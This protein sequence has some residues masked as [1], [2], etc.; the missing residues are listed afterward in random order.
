MK[1]IL[2]VSK[3]KS[4]GSATG[5]TSHNY[6]L[7]EV[8]NADPDR[9]HLNQEY[10]NRGEKNI[11]ELATDRIEQAGIKTV[12]KDAVRGM[13][14]LITASP[15]AFP[16]DESGVIKGDY[17]NSTW[18][19]DNLK[20]LSQ[21][22][23]A[24]LVAFTLHQD[25]KTPHI[26]AIVVPITA[27]N[28]LSAKDL[29]NPKTLK[30]LQTDYAQAMQSH[31]LERGVEGSRARHV[32]MQKVY[33]L[34]QQTRQELEQALKTAP[35]THQRLTVDKPGTWDL[36]NLEQWKQQQEAKIN[37]EVERRMKELQQKGQKAQNIAVA[38]I[39]EAERAKVLQQRLNTSEGLKQGNYAKLVQTQ[40]DL[41]KS[42]QTLKRVGLL[43]HEGRLNPEWSQKVA[44]QS[45]QEVTQ[46]LDQQ[47]KT[48]L[49]GSVANEKAVFDQ[50]KAHGYKLGKKENIP[51]L[52]HESS[53]VRLPLSLI[54]IEGKDL[55]ES[56]NQAKERTQKQEQEKAQKQQRNRGLGMGF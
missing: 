49:K 38:T 51:Y 17:R 46:Q 47:L 26:H 43:A 52:E 56:I 42:R 33:G 35:A 32:E 16:R 30:T 12:R 34:Q 45:R 24:N 37:A 14:F 29:F 9:K 53:Q 39:T 28:R 5:K 27:D 31:G 20:F 19:A 44:E 10:L 25:E 7:A 4:A 41:T 36:L 11:W 40:T 18:V 21:R 15:G 22:Y 54:R 2:R 50:L 55:I 13:E 8:P 1:C 6:R 48:I 23:G 3:I